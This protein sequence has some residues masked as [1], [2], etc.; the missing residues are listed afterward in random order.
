MPE[1]VRFGEADGR[2]VSPWIRADRSVEHCIDAVGKFRL[3]A[4]RNDDLT[5]LALKYKGR[6]H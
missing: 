5:M 6:E 3:N 4:E 2:F 1:R